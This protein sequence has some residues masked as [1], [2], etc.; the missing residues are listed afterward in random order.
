MDQEVYY[1]NIKFLQFMFFSQNFTFSWIT[2][3]IK[4]NGMQNARIKDNGLWN[5]A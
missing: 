1:K 5:T 2:D 3:K 4:D